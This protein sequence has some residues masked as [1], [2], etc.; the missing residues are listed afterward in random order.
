[1]TDIHNNVYY[2]SNF[3]DHERNDV[4]QPGEWREELGNNVFERVQICS[5][6]VIHI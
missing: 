2:P 1:M 4:F 5:P 3:V 6:T